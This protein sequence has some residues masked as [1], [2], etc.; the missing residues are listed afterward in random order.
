M[1]DLDEDE[2]S[3]D[4]EDPSVFAKSYDLAQ[5]ALYFLTDS[6]RFQPPRKKIKY[7]FPLFLVLKSVNCLLHSK[8]NVDFII[9]FIVKLKIYMFVCNFIEIK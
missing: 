8:F 4:D 9:R 7:E 2:E 6:D 5:R 3:S 1:N